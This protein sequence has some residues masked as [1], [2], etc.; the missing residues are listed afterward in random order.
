MFV[1]EG[2]VAKA[3][4]GYLAELLVQGLLAF[5]IYEV[6]GGCS[7]FRPRLLSRFR[8]VFG[9]APLGAGFTLALAPLAAA[10]P[11][12]PPAAYSPSGS[13]RAPPTS[14]SKLASFSGA[15]SSG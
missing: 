9:L 10:L 11:P 2:S 12:L 6:A 8:L 5:V 4:C 3:H 13:S 1:R 14:D 15:K 7:M